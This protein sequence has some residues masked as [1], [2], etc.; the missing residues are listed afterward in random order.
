MRNVGISVALFLVSL[1]TCAQD[2][3][4]PK[5]S[6]GADP[7]LDRFITDWYS[8]E[9]KILEE[10]SLLQLSKTPSAESYRFLWLRTF[11]HPIAIRL[12]LRNDGIGILSTKVATGSSGFPQKGAHP[13]ENI[14]RPLTR[15]QTQSF[16]ERINRVGFWTV[17]KES[18]DQGGEDGA[19]WIIEGVKQ[20]NYRV[21]RRWSP[22]EGP[23]HEL[24]LTFVFGLAQMRIPK[25]DIY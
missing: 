14:S 9:L 23:V 25:D 20:G 21:V 2:Q 1:V 24:G 4:F 5:K 17:Q 6:F 16:L 12:E 10:P 8:N 19:E 13:L 22:T 7:Q 3:F 11:H 15:E 18:E